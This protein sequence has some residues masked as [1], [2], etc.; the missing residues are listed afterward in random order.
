[1]L[2]L[3][4]AAALYAARLA[5]ERLSGDGAS[6]QTHWGG[7]GGGLGGWRMSPTLFLLVLA[8]GFAGAAVGLAF[9]PH[10]AEK[11]LVQEDRSAAK[12]APAKAA[13]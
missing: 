11:G 9:E 6:V 13:Q 4:T 12:P 1:M 7:I 2:A 10:P 3:F 5:I 8:L